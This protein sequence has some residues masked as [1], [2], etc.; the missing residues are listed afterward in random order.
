MGTTT[1]RGVDLTS[2]VA[3]AED[4]QSVALWRRRGSRRGSV[5]SKRVTP[6]LE[7]RESRSGCTAA[8]PAFNRTREVGLPTAFTALVCRRSRAV[9]L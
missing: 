7:T 3:C 6:R 1:H 5:L 4:H 8:C 2:K 9:H